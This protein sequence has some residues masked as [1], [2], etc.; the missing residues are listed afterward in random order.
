[1]NVKNIK[2]S[3]LVLFGL[4]IF[5]LALFVSAE[6]NSDNKNNIFLDSDQDG[7]SD[8]EE[9][10]LGTDP[11]NKDTDKDSY[12]DGVEIKTGYNPL[13]PA[14][15][16][17]LVTGQEKE[18]TTNTPTVAGV[19][20]KEKNLTKNLSQKIS[21]LTTERDAQG[22]TVSQDDLETIIDEVLLDNPQE[23]VLPE[24]KKEDLKIKKQDYE[25]YSKEKAK[26]KRKEDFS[27]YIISVFYVFS[28]NSPEPLTSKTNL[29]NVFASLSQEI[30]E[31]ISLRNPSSLVKI[32]NSLEKIQEQLMEIEV[33]EELTETHTKIIQFARY[34]LKAEQLLVP[35]NEDPV[36][37]ISNLYHLIGLA[38]EIQSFSSELEEKFSEYGFT[39]DAGTKE[40]I[41]SLGLEIPGDLEKDLEKTSQK[42][43]EE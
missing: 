12:S 5:S 13:K 42:I 32:N 2:I 23:I 15:G 19:N 37:D 33:P 43:Q 17:K 9:K 10:A 8:E 30:I 14:P 21:S 16:D 26:E 35:Q 25:K 3:L 34:S 36:A 39:Y 29:G 31:A 1:M 20:T 18:K 41:E 24:I 40:I 4:I 38:T 22:D 11:K 6:N 27:N 7:L 28:I